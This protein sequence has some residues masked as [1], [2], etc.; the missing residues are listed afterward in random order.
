MSALVNA[1]RRA[2][3]RRIGL[4]ALSAPVAGAL[5]KNVV[6]AEASENVLSQGYAKGGL[7]VGWASDD[8]SFLA[9]VAKPDNIANRFHDDDSYRHKMSRA[10]YGALVSVSPTARLAYLNRRDK[11]ERER[12]RSW[13]ESLLRTLPFMKEGDL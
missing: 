10:H 8:R 12:T 9:D 4:G 6:G 5:L 7:A 13:A 3:F 1:A 11:A 2:L